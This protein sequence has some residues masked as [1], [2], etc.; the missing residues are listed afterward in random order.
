M[1]MQIYAASP[2]RRSRQIAG[3]VAALIGIG[4]SVAIG[5]LVASLIRALAAVGRAVEGAGSSFHDRLSTAA[6]ALARLPLVG[7]AASRPLSS[8]GGAG[9]AL[10]DAGRQQEQLIG[11]LALAVGLILAIVP[12]LVILRFWLVRRVRFARQA[13]EARRLSESD[14]GLQLLAFR[15]LVASD[16][17]ELMRMHPNPIASWSAGDAL[18]QRLLA[19]LALR[20]AGVLR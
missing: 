20:D 1:G 3:D 2:A 9:T 7:D 5:V 17:R 12:S 18:E 13:A 8:A 15:A 10:A 19:E 6:E 16:T 4:L 14:G 11:H